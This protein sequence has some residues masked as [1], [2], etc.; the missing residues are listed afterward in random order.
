VHP[1]RAAHASSA[2]ELTDLARGAAVPVWLPWPVPDGWLVTGFARAGDDGSGTRG[3]VLALS[4][5]NP[6]GGPGEMLLISEEPGIGLGARFAGLGGTDPGGD[7]A[8]GPPDGLVRYSHHEFPLWHV[9]GPER[10]A[11]VGE[12]MGSWLWLVLWPA[13]AGLLLVE[14]LE[15]VDLRDPG[16]ELELP[17][18]APSPL[19]HG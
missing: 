8:A 4:G 19:L 1:L 6:V 10:A 9:D 3:C 2:E 5:P 11:F 18:G 12:A 16:V 13:T 14:Q 7:V 15:L 17:F